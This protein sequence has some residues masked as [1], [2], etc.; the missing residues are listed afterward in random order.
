MEQVGLHPQQQVLDVAPQIEPS[1]TWAEYWS[2]RDKKWRHNVERCGRRLAERG[3]VS[4]LRYRPQGSAC[5]DDD[6]RWDLYDSC[7]D[8]A[9]RS[10]QSAADDGTTLSSP[11]VCQYLRDTHEAAARRGCVDLN[12]LLLD[13][14]AVA[15]AY[16]YVY[17]G[18]LYG[19]RK[20]FDPE[21]AAVRPGLVL[22][23][24]MIEDGIGRGDRCYD[25]GVGSLD[26]KRPW[27]TG[28]ATS[29][30]FTHFPATASRVQLLRL[31]RWLLGRFRDRRAAMASDQC[32]S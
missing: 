26:I 23:A 5:G 27:Q 20:G 9:R 4:L 8:L 16:N 30:R 22:D 7:V 21:L 15:F 11:T 1:G 19:L 31:K 29:Y 17:D 6:P 24:R 13:G 18:R 28:M 32:C 25:L 12:L 10:W 3:E 14:R 2:S